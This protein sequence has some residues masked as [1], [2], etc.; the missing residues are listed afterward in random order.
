MNEKHLD[1]LCAVLITAVEGGIN[2]WT[3]TI[4]GYEYDQSN[5]MKYASANIHYERNEHIIN[6]EV[7][8]A[9]FR[10]IIEDKNFQ[11]NGNIAKNIFYGYLM[12]DAGEIDDEMADCIVQASIFGE[13]VYG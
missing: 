2:Y 9:G 1:F 10:K 5:P 8:E 11:I 3:S 6:P 4:S 13:I 7:I 12:D